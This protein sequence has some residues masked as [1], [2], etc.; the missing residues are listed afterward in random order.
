[1]QYV[2]LLSHEYEWR[3]DLK[4]VFQLVNTGK[5]RKLD[6]NLNEFIWNLFNF[7]RNK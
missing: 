2:F 6:L 1:M 5:T 4:E 3:N 7:Q